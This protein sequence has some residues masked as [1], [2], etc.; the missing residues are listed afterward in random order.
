MEHWN[1]RQADP[2]IVHGAAAGLAFMTHH[3]NAI[4]VFASNKDVA[5]T[6]AALLAAAT[7]AGN[8]TS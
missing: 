2:S 8:R 6:Q 4:N 1:D 5:A 3:M 7:D